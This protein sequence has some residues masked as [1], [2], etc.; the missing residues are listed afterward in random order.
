MPIAECGLKKK[1]KKSE[2]RNL[3]SEITG[4]MFLPHNALASGPQAC[5]GA[6]KRHFKVKVGKLFSVVNILQMV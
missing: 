1:L 5:L 4:P 3:Q 6:E 2:I